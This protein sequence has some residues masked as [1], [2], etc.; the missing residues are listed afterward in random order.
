M[1]PSAAIE[2]FPQV[3]NIPSPKHQKC[4][5]IMSR[6]AA[7]IIASYK[8]A[9]EQCGSTAYLELS[10]FFRQVFFA[11][12]SWTLTR[13]M[14]I[15][16]LAKMSEEFNIFAY[17]QRFVKEYYIN[18]IRGVIIPGS[19]YVQYVSVIQVNVPA[20][21][22]FRFGLYNSKVCACTDICTFQI[23]NVAICCVFLSGE[24]VIVLVCG[25]K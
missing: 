7:D 20:C 13:E 4:N 22:T 15:P 2:H 3:N 5:K 10:Q 17:Q 11:D 16:L 8:Q 21:T 6:K 19:M 23:T 14:T 25:S 1:Y 12:S 18:K 9:L 24:D